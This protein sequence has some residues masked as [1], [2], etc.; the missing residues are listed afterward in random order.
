MLLT[1]KVRGCVDPQL[2]LFTVECSNDPATGR[3][4]L[5]CI[6]GDRIRHHEM[7]LTVQ[8]ALSGTADGLQ[9]STVRDEVPEPNSVKEL[10][11]VL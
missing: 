10:N 7:S 9:L 3:G 4:N 5:Q 2:G 11:T 1:G 8:E 6:K